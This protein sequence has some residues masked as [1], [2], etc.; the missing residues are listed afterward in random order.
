[1]VLENAI[2]V[3]REVITITIKERLVQNTTNGKVI[4]LYQMSQVTLGD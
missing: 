1:M 3:Y 4:N 2:K